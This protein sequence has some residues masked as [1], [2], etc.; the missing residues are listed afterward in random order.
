M[1]GGGTLRSLQ[2]VKGS[3]PAPTVTG[4][5]VLPA[6]ESLAVGGT[7]VLAALLTYSDGTSKDVT[8]TAAWVI[9]DATILGWVNP[10]ITGL[11]AGTA[12][13]TATHSGHSGHTTIT[14]V[15]AG[16][17]VG[18]LLI[19]NPTFGYTPPDVTFLS[20]LAPDTY[21]Q[22]NEV[23]GQLKALLLLN[24]NWQVISDNAYTNLVARVLVMKWGDCPHYLQIKAT[25]A[26]A[27]LILSIRDMANAADIST[28]TF[29]NYGQ[30]WNAQVAHVL[31]GPDVWIM[32]ILNST[33]GGDWIWFNASDGHSYFWDDM[34]GGLLNSGA[35]ADVSGFL[36]FANLYN[37]GSTPYGSQIDAAGNIAVVPL[38]CWSGDTGELFGFCKA[39]LSMAGVAVGN[40]YN[41]GP[42]VYYAPLNGGST[43]WGNF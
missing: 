6:V 23:I 39:S 13:A 7:Q 38:T 9:S 5:V 15:A 8:A 11:L 34:L 30:T 27:H 20:T 19:P 21:N 35:M 40:W 31:S 18:K 1:I 26:A 32:D 42:T 10:T 17:V 43:L 36:S 16:S 25:G 12:T 2:P 33:S 28:C 24:A 14:V 4:L 22:A 29:N 41:D 37:F 3:K